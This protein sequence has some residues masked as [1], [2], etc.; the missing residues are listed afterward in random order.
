MS[1]EKRSNLVVVLCVA[2]VL[3]LISTQIRKAPSGEEFELVNGQ[4]LQTNQT[5]DGIRVIGRLTQVSINPD[6][7]IGGVLQFVS[8]DGYR[9]TALANIPKDRLRNLNLNESY[10]VQGSQ[11]SPGTI[12]LRNAGSISRVSN[13]TSE[14][15][16][17]P[18]ALYRETNT[19]GMARSVQHGDFFIQATFPLEHDV[20][21]LGYWSTPASG[22]GLPTFR[23][24]QI[25]E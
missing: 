24:T 20:T 1:L 2:G 3:A 12:S 25:L 16:V 4:Y 18:Y 5:R 7:A 15:T 9:F 19:A 22:R 10:E 14:S 17:T 11:I 13:I 6:S 23:A 21:Y 8:D